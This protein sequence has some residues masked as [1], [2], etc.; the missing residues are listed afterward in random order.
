MHL[1]VDPSTLLSSEADLRQ[2][3]AELR[4]T[5]A[6]TARIS[7]LRDPSVSAGLAQLTDVCGDALE[8]VACDLDLVATRVGAAAVVY[9]A[10]ERVV[11]GLAGLGRSA[12]NP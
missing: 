9:T 8:L 10:T 3:G 7:G 12:G 6:A 5:A 2:R 1:Q 4:G 11:A